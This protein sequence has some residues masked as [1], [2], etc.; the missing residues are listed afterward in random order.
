MNDLLI[1][2]PQADLGVY[3]GVTAANDRTP[4]LA[5]SGSTGEV[6]FG[7]NEGADSTISISG[8]TPPVTGF[9]TTYGGIKFH[10]GA[11]GR[12]AATKTTDADQYWGYVDLNLYKR[13]AL[14]E[15][16]VPV[17]FDLNLNLDLDL[18]ASV[19]GSSHT[20]V[21][22]K[23][24]LGGNI[25][26]ESDPDLTIP[27]A[28]LNAMGPGSHPVTL[29]VTPGDMLPQDGPAP[30]RMLTLE[31]VPEPATMA[32]LGLGMAIGLVRRRR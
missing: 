9:P 10:E 5:A 25:Y 6:N 12:T 31:L 23:W 28:V 4:F 30:S 14:A 16:S 24:Q 1:V 11:T 3:R 7:A 2:H 27:W 26:T 18:H 8:K 13:F 32:L 21:A 17:N 20:A 15:F 22:Y 29:T 19:G